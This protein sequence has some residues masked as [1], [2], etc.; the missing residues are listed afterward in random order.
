[1]AD[2]IWGDTLR[3]AR[4]IIGIVKTQMNGVPTIS[5]IVLHIVSKIPIYQNIE[6]SIYCNRIERFD[7]SDFRSF[8]ISKYRTCLARHPLATGKPMFFM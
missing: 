7:V 1:M 2:E 4:N 8:D 6:V 5:F 3:L